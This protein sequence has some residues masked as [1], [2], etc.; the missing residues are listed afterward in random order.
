M[1]VIQESVI[2]A[3]KESLGRALP[4]NNN[5]WI[6]PS[7]IR[8]IHQKHSVR[9]QYGPS[10]MQY[11]IAKT[12]CKKLCK[13]DKENYINSLHSE[14]SSIPTNAQYFVAMKRLNITHQYPK[15]NWS[16][17]SIDG[18]VLTDREKINGRWEEFYK[19]LYFSERANFI[20][21]EETL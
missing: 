9:Q 6:T 19:N 10:S 13:I 14:I 11:K 17:K 2:S 8:Y 20:P 7:T 5:K 1:N 12:N 18:D 3:S 16:V 15:T 21:F 4:A